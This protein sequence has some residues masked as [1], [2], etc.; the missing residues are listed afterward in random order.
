MIDP[1]ISHII[2][3]H[4]EIITTPIR[5]QIQRSTSITAEEDAE[6]QSLRHLVM[7]IQIATQTKGPRKVT[8]SMKLIKEEI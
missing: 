5:A 4:K 1:T 3:R 7:P 2:L 6:D 8:D